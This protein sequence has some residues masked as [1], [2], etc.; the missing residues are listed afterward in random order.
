MS[1]LERRRADPAA[2]RH[3]RQV[4]DGPL[5]RRLGRLQPD[6]HRRGVRAGRRSARTD[7]PRALDDGAGGA[8]PDRGGG[9]PGASEAPVG[10]VPRHGHARAGGRR[11][12]APSARSATVAR[13]ST[14]SPSRR[15]SRSSATPRPSSRSEPSGQGCPPRLARLQSGHA[16]RAAGADPVQGG[17]G[18]PAHRPAGRISRRSPPTPSSTAAPRRSATSSRCSRSRACSR[19]RTPPPGACR[20]TPASATSSTA[21]SPRAEGL[22]V[23][24]RMS[25]SR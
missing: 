7:P 9:R 16:H 8:R 3:A 25:S 14:R 19:T 12:A 20:P 22:A 23:Q 6:P 10:A 5:R 2:A 4:P 18:L 17:R 21:C 1:E 15:A 13:S 24:R 11:D